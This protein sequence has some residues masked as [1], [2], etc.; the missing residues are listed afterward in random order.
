M[1]HLPH[2]LNGVKT[3]LDIISYAMGKENGYNQGYVAGKVNVEL[4]STLVF[5]D[6][7]EGNIT[8]TE[9]E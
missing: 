2:G 7:G 9:G 3:M 4:D 6:D 5:T 8:I 1:R